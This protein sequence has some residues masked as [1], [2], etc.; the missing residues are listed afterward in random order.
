MVNVMG[1]G[2]NLKMTTAPIVLKKK[3]MI[4]L[5]TIVFIFFIYPANCQLL[6]DI[7]AHFIPFGL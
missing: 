2:T 4:V 7:M 1:I 5:R 3:Y 6:H